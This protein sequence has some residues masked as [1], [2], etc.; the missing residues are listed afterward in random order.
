MGLP[1][2]VKQDVG[3]LDVTVDYIPGMSVV[4]SLCHDRH[5]LSRLPETTT[6]PVAAARPRPSLNVL[7]DNVAKAAGGWPTS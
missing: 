6:G 4:Q 5:K 1:P 3:R 7:G 2:G